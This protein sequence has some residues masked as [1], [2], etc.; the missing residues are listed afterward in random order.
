[1]KTE[2]P[3]NQGEKEITNFCG[4]R[5]NDI[6]IIAPPGNDSLMD[7]NDKEFNYDNQDNVKLGKHAVVFLVFLFTGPIKM[8]WVACY[9]RS[10]SSTRNEQNDSPLQTN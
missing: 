4:Q 3:I 1:M 9:F 6:N 7:N 8:V 10:R 5:N 2:G